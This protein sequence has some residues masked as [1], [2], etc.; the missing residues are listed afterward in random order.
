MADAITTPMTRTNVMASVTS[1]PV[2]KGA[3]RLRSLAASCSGSIYVVS[4]WVLDRHPHDFLVCGHELVADLHAE[5]QR[6][7]FTLQ[8]DHRVVHVGGLLHH[9]GHRAVGGGGRVL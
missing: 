8:R 7:L 4:S 9:S 2:V 5:L 3:V 1:C 6:Q